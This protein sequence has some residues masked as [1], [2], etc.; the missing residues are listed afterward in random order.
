MHFSV[1]LITPQK[2]STIQVDFF[3]ASAL[4]SDYMF[5]HFG[6]TCCLHLQGDLIGWDGGWKHPGP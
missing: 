1:T 3:W 6:G 4:L 2:H 5:W